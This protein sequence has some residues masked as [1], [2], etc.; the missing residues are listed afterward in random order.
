MIKPLEFNKISKIRLFIL[1]K[2]YNLSLK[3]SHKNYF[4]TTIVLFRICFMISPYWDDLWLQ[5]LQFLYRNEKYRKAA[6]LYKESIYLSPNYST[7]HKLGEFISKKGTIND[8]FHKEFISL[9]SDA[10]LRSMLISLS[11]SNTIYH[12]SKFCY[13]ILCSIL[14][15]L[16]TTVLKIL[17]DQLTKIILVGHIIPTSSHKLKLSTKILHVTQYFSSR[18]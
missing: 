3:Y 17:K 16:N 7:I 1:L 12:P 15:K 10:E 6:L 14:F 2:I 5:Y 4:Y 18:K 8:S 11:N 13:I 9:I